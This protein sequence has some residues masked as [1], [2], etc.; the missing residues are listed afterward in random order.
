MKM[1]SPGNYFLNSKLKFIK[2]ANRQDKINNGVKNLKEGYVWI[3]CDCQPGKLKL[4]SQRSILNGKVKTCGVSYN[5]PLSKKLKSI[6]NHNAINFDNLSG[7]FFDQI[8]VISPTGTSTHYG[9][10]YNCKC[11]Y[12]NKIFITCSKNIKRSLS[13]GKC[14]YH[15]ILL[16]EANSF[17]TKEEVLLGNARHLFLSKH[18]EDGNSYS[19]YSDG[20]LTELDFIN[21]CSVEILSH[22]TRTKEICCSYCG[23]LE[24]LIHKNYKYVKG[25]SKKTIQCEGLKYFI[26]DRFINNNPNGSKTLHNKEN[27]RLACR[28]CSS[29]K[30]NHSPQY[31][32]NHLEKMR[33]NPKIVLANELDI[34]QNL[35]IKNN[36]KF[37]ELSSLYCDIDTENRNKWNRHLKQAL[38]D[39][40]D[41]KTKLNF[42]P[43]I[44]LLE[45]DIMN[46]KLAP[47]ICCGKKSDI[48][49]AFLM[50]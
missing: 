46:L 16:G 40:K 27:L 8:E 44:Q 19:A 43:Q 36:L 14:D 39:I 41:K 17:K 49:K 2:C 47:C 21:L 32:A 34:C 23:S 11:L 25:S 6:N 33:E 28:I 10:E 9:K 12:C 31:F 24:Y 15:K 42:V 29:A 35:M 4:K 48:K 5:C 30:L 3:E 7:Q 20:N 13:C 22:M 1:P 37:D 50:V 18:K 26:L 45:I 38:T